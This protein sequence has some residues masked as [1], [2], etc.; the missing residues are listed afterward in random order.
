[1]FQ[2]LSVSTRAAA[3]RGC[4]N[5][6]PVSMGM[7]MSGLGR[8]EGVGDQGTV[9]MSGTFNLLRTCLPWVAVAGRRDIRGINHCHI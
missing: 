6:G 3:G 4:I 2:I 1:M 7:G 9:G 5:Y 8:E